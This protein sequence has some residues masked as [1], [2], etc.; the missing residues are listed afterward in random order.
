MRYVCL[1]INNHVPGANIG[2][3]HILT[4]KHRKFAENDENW[5][6]LDSLLNEL[7]RLPKDHML[8]QDDDCLY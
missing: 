4:R 8:D 6:D 2:Y 3:Q 7:S 1:A 5:T